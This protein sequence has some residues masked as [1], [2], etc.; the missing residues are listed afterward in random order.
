[1][2]FIGFIC[3]PCACCPLT[4]GLVVP[5]EIHRYGEYQPLFQALDLSCAYDIEQQARV[6]AQ[7]LTP[8]NTA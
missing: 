3:N 7:L 2:A 8:Q 4:I 5:N 6:G 1:M